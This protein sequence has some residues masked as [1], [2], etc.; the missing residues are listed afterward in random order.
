[1]STSPI[2]RVVVILNP[3][4][5]HLR[6]AGMFVEKAKQFECEIKVVR[7]GYAVDAKSIIDLVTL[8]AS[9]GTQLSIEAMGPD[10]GEAVEVLSQLV[11]SGFAEMETP[12]G[13]APPAQKEG[14]ASQAGP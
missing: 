4:G 8:G 3:L 5:L 9:Q 14:P 13:K 1:M 10:A 11:A 7:E 2:R 12:A 6:P